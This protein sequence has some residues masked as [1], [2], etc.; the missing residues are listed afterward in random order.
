MKA[1]LKKPV[2]IIGYSGHAYVIID[3]LLSAGRLVTAYC[4]SSEKEKNPYHLQYLGKESEALDKLKDYDV[5]ACV[6]HN[7][8]REKIHTQMSELLGN[9]INAIHPSAVISSS[10]KLGDGIM[11]AANATINPLAEIG[12][13]VICNTSSSIDHECI[14]EDFAH[15][16]PGAVLCGNVKVGKNTFVGANAVIRQ[17]IIIGKNVMIGA[18]TVVVKDIPDNTTVVGNPQR[19]LT[20]KEQASK[21]LAA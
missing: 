15:I 4:D 10:V 12:R 18:G 14:I 7:G 17:G 1:T 6:G 19:I 9:P 5:F 16:G 2:A 21:L 20:K 11:I 13:G 8:I 3:I